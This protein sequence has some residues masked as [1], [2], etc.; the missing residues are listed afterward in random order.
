[1]KNQLKNPLFFYG[2]KTVDYR[3]KQIVRRVCVAAIQDGT[4]LRIAT[5][6]CSEKDRFIKKK[7]RAIAA[8]R[9]VG[10]PEDMLRLTEEGTVASQFTAYCRNLLKIAPKEQLVVA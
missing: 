1:M 4:V 9:A 6:T 7:G 10:K 3:G 8:G 2:E 5:A